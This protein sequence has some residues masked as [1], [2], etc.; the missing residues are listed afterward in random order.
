M[1]IK[2]E[3]ESVRMGNVEEDHAFSL[4]LR[5]LAKLK[6]GERLKLAIDVDDTAADVSTTVRRVLSRRHG[7][8]FESGKERFD[9]SSSGV[10]IERY[11]KA[12]NELWGERWEQINPLLSREAFHMLS[13][14]TDLSLVS[15]RSEE[16]AEPLYRW[17]AKHYG[18][19]ARVTVLDSKPY[20][21]HGIRKL[22]AGY[23]LLVDDSPH[24]S[25]TMSHELA[26]GK[27]LLLVNRWED[28][29]ENRNP[30]NTAVVANVEHAADLIFDAHE[31]QDRR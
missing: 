17:V 28:A 29:L 7:F 3:S 23:D 1:L 22:K 8:D 24:V 10:T 11:I 9:W 18:K 14:R 25:R 12:Y 5:Q 30:A 2:L 13:E 4:I 16:T 21:M 26:R 19:K 31:I 20:E 15:A 6:K 27:A